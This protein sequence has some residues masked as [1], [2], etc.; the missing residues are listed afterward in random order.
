MKTIKI[1]EHKYLSIFFNILI[2]QFNYDLISYGKVQ[3][4][5]TYKKLS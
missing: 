5:H 3:E 1:L 2:L 4:L